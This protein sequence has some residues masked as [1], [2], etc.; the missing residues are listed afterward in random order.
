[1]QSNIYIAAEGIGR[2]SSLLPLMRKNSDLLFEIQTLSDFGGSLK[3]ANII[4]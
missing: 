3:S 1:M 4:L 2:T